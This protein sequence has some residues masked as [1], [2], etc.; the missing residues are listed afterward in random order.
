MISLMRHGGFLKFQKSKN[1]AEVDCLTYDTYKILQ[2]VGKSRRP[3]IKIY[4]KV[5]LQYLMT[6][7]FKDTP[8]IKKWRKC[9]LNNFMLYCIGSTSP[10][11][12][13][14]ELNV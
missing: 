12:L 8:V 4:P 11:N 13:T 1:T 3:M 2:L 6:K 10:E 7:D 14:L 5:C 9:N